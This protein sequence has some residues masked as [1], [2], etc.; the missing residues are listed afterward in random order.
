MTKRAREQLVF[1]PKLRDRHV[2]QAC[3]SDNQRTLFD[4]GDARTREGSMWTHDAVLSTNQRQISECEHSS[5]DWVEGCARACPGCYVGLG[6]SSA[7]CLSKSCTVLRPSPR[8][9]QNCTT[10]RS[11]TRQ[12]FSWPQRSSRAVNTGHL[13]FPDGRGRSELMDRSYESCI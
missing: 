3:T 13:A 12:H 1:D 7:R 11:T 8:H 6:T 9:D 4:R 5:M 10:T 2:S